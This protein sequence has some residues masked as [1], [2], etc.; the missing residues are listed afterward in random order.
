MPPSSSN[1]I[2]YIYY[3][4]Y[5]YYYYV[6]SMCPAT[7]IRE[8][9]MAQL[10][11]VYTVTQELIRLNRIGRG[12]IGSRQWAVGSGQWAVRVGWCG[13]GGEGSYQN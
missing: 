3:E 4:Y 9:I 8:S 12:L 6:E 5:Y 10:P 7:Q 11:Q 1:T 2:I 13:G